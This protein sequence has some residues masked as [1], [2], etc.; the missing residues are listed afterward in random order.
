M[1][2]TS[3]EFLIER[4]KDVDVV[5]APVLGREYHHACLQ[6]VE[7]SAIIATVHG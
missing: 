5:A 1:A 4:V 2:S 3:V 6:R 7:G